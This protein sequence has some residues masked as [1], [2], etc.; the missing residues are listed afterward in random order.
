M[1]ELADIHPD[2]LCSSEFDSNQ[3]NSFLKGC[4]DC[5]PTVL[6]YLSIGFSAGAL[7]SFSGMS[8][9]EVC[10]LSLILYAGS[11]Q[12]IVASL[13]ASNTEVISISIAIFFVNLRHLLMSAYLAPFFKEYS[14]VKRF[15]IGSQITDETFGVASIQ[16]TGTDRIDFKWMLGL[17]LTAYINWLIG[18]FTGALVASAIPEKFIG[19]LQF[20]LVSMFIGLVVA[21]IKSTSNVKF[22]ICL[23]LLSLAI[24]QPISLVLGS[25]YGVITTA[26]TVS[27]IGMVVKKWKLDT[28][29]S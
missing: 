2:K 13:V 9:V 27:F 20:A 15:I 4:V 1:T 26:V 11:G 19:S 24:V 22:Q 17:N 14:P 18:N 3:Q 5:V 7:A 28:K 6:G 29:Y 16:K 21:H 23:A 8:P 10:L 12:F 25:S